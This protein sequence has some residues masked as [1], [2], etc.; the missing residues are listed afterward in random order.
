MRTSKEMLTFSGCIKCEGQ[1]YKHQKLTTYKV[2]NE[3]NIC[4]KTTAENGRCYAV[5][6]KMSRV[7]KTNA[8]S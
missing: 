1:N 5:R 8:D 4:V 6:I 3:N 7:S 2:Q